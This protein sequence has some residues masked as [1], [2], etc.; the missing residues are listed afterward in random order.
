MKAFSLIGVGV[1]IE[2]VSLCS[3]LTPFAISQIPNCVLDEETG[4]LVCADPPIKGSEC[5]VRKCNDGFGVGSG[6]ACR[7][8]NGSLKGS[9]IQCSDSSIQAYFCKD[10]DVESDICELGKYGDNA[11]TEEHCGQRRPADC[12]KDTKAPRG[13]KCVEKEGPFSGTCIIKTCK[14]PKS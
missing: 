7:W 14:N 9:C 2:I 3:L 1:L 12:V 8:E 4:M 10:T 13:A 6:G 11:K 5:K